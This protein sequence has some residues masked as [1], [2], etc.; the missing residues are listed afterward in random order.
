MHILR[1][2]NL[3]FLDTDNVSVRIVGAFHIVSRSLDLAQ[4][5]RYGLL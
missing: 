5:S 4:S 2:V 1:S 3:G